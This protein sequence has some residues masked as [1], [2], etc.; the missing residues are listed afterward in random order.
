MMKR[1]LY[2]FTFAILA[3]GPL[4]MIYPQEQKLLPTPT[5]TIKH[6]PRVTIAPVFSADSKVIATACEHSPIVKVW[7]L[8]DGK[9]MQELERPGEGGIISLQLSNS[10]ALVAIAS[11]NRS[12][13]VLRMADGTQ[14]A[15]FAT[16]PFLPGPLAFSDDDRLVF[17]VEEFRFDTQLRSCNIITGVDK[18][19]ARGQTSTATIQAIKG[20]PLLIF[21]IGDDA[22]A[23]DLF[24]GNAVSFDTKDPVRVSQHS[25]RFSVDHL[26]TFLACASPTADFVTVYQLN[27]RKEAGVVELPFGRE[28]ID[29]KMIGGTDCRLVVASA[30]RKD[31]KCFIAIYDVL[32]KTTISQFET[33]ELLAAISVSRDSKYVAACMFSGDVNV[34]EIGAVPSR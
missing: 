12:V 33:N 20:G 4:L 30:S 34:W 18:I 16:K 6:G 13:C 24:S 1:E 28:I 8:R 25:T 31:R 27:G 9:L 3:F 5:V 32:K 29:L 2:I 23:V 22:S 15:S 26:N 21:S 7:S 14:A 17:C 19:V 11:L 10:L